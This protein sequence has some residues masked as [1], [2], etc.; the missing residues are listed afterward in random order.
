[1]GKADVALETH[2]NGIAGLEKDKC[3]Q[4]DFEQET[5]EI[6]DL[7][8]KLGSGEKVEVRKASPK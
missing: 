5:S 2:E 6:R 1:M 4:S 3:N 7:I 8:E